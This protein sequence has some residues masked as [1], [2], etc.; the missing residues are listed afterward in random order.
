MSISQPEFVQEQFVQIT[1][2]PPIE[3]EE[4]MD[5]GY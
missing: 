2:T 1:L 3:G 5:L 4:L